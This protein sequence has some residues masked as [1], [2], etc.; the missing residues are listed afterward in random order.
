MKEFHLGNDLISEPIDEM[1][2]G[3]AY[4][5]SKTD[6]EG[7][8]THLDKFWKYFISTWLV[9][10]DPILWNVWGFEVREEYYFRVVNRTNNPL[11][12]FNRAVNDLLIHP[13]PCME[14]FVNIIKTLSNNAVDENRLIDMNMK[15]RPVHKPVTM[16]KIPDDYES[17]PFV[18]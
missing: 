12:R 17:F 13:N 9:K 18:F 2:K 11:E 14:L 16:Y 8:M 7:K 4:C 15:P 5:R 10:Y 1:K 3:I 6:R